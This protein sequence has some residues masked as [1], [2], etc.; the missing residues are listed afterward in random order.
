MLKTPRDIIEKY[1][2]LTNNKSNLSGN[3]KKK[4]DRELA[5]LLD[6]NKQLKT[7]AQKYTE[8]DKLETNKT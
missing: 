8:L 2:E 5:Q 7:D 6:F 3:K 4:I 1:N